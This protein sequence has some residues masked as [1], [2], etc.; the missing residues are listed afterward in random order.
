MAVLYEGWTPWVWFY[1]LMPPVWGPVSSL[2]W[3]AVKVHLT[4]S[5]HCG[6]EGVLVIVIV[7]PLFVPHPKQ[8]LPP[9]SLQQKYGSMITNCRRASDTGV[10]LVATYFRADIVRIPLMGKK[11]ILN[12]ERLFRKSNSSRLIFSFLFSVCF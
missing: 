12:K 11:N 8:G 3:A 2:I 4:R 1:F 10:V 6:R 5:P 7:S 9:Q